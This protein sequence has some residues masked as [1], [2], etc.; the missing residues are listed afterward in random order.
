[1]LGIFSCALIAIH[2]SFLVGYLSKSYVFLKI[3]LFVFLLLS[4]ESPLCILDI[5]PLWDVCFAKI[6]SQ[7][8]AY[9]PLYSVF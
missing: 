1:M 7:S 3:G 5:N 2:K 8:V 6:F 4:F 9:H